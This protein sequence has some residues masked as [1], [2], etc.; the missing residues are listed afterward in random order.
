MRTPDSIVRLLQQVDPRLVRAAIK[1]CDARLQ[2]LTAERKQLME[3]LVETDRSSGGEDLGP[4][5]PVRAESASSVAF[6]A[7]PRASKTTAKTAGVT[8]SDLTLSIERLLQNNG[9]RWMPLTAIVK[10]FP[11]YRGTVKRILEED[12]R[13]E[14]RDGAWRFTG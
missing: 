4:Q 11:K 8:R 7:P 12:T 9:D 14:E 6:E 2:E 10:Q 5:H 3:L 1:D 13:F